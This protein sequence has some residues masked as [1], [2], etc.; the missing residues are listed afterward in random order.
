MS[1][2][3]LSKVFLCVLCLIFLR[4][5]KFVKLFDFI[6]IFFLMEFTQVRNTKKT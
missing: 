5:F 4:S 2:K 6:Q 1:M 3:S